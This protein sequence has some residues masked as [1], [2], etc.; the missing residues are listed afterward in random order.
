MQYKRQRNVV[1][2]TGRRLSIKN[3]QIGFN[4][5]VVKT[6]AKPET[7]IQSNFQGKKVSRDPIK[8]KPNE[9]WKCRKDNRTYR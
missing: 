9:F 4:Q 7:I 3:T 6:S 1:L 8:A 5:R 2:R